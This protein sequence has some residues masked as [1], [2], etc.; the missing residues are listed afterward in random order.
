MFDD[1][2]RTRKAIEKA[3]Q[4]IKIERKKLREGKKISGICYKCGINK[5]ASWNK[6][7]ICTACQQYKKS[8]LK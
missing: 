1:E 4:L 8:N 6:K 7:G 2:E 5:L 3:D